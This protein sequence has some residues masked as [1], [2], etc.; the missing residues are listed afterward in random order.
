MEVKGDSREYLELRRV[1]AGTC[2]EGSQKGGGGQSDA[3]CRAQHFGGPAQSGVAFDRFPQSL[4]EAHE[5][6]AMWAEPAQCGLGFQ[7]LFQAA[8]GR[9]VVDVVPLQEHQIPQLRL[10]RVQR[11]GR[12]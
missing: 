12:L 2:A 6:M 8:C 1:Q 5:G 4:D 3:Q 10:G 7:I 9:V 11:R